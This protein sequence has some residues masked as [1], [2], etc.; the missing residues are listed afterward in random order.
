M[1]ALKLFQDDS[2]CNDIVGAVVTRNE[3]VLLPDGTSHTVL[4]A[5]TAL[6]PGLRSRVF[7]PSTL[8]TLTLPGLL[9]QIVGHESHLAVT[10]PDLE[11]GFEMLTDTGADFDRIVLALDRADALEP[12]ALRYI[13]FATREFPLQLVFVGGLKLRTLLAGEEFA[14]LRRSF[15]EYAPDTA[16]MDAPGN[17]PVELAQPNVVPLPVGPLPV[18]P[19]VSLPEHRPAYLGRRRA[20]LLA[21]TGVAASVAGLAWLVQSGALAPYLEANSLTSSMFRPHPVSAQP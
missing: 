17:I 5:V 21:G 20:W 8:D 6:L 9:S 15:I 3:H 16:P 12:A 1:P 13:Q 4:D 14:S 11:H 7:R 19:V 10:A 18:G 2:L